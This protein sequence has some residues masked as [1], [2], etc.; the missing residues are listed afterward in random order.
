MRRAVK[1]TQCWGKRRVQ[2]LER[3]MIG[4]GTVMGEKRKETDLSD[5]GSHDGVHNE[6]LNRKAARPHGGGKGQE[7]DQELLQHLP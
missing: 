7:R 4:L 3:S 1:P 2:E 5:K 6:K